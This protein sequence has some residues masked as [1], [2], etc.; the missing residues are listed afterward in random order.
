M[1]LGVIGCGNISP[2]YFRA[3]EYF[4][5]LEFIAC[6]DLDM[7]VARARAAEF[8]IPEVLPVSE[9]LEHPEIEVIVNLTVPQV[10]AAVS[11]AVLE[12]GKHVYS[13]KPLATSLEDA[14]GLLELADAK[15]LRVACAPL[16]LF[17]CGSANLP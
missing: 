3:K 17:R 16:D 7:D 13:E 1:K 8:N 9:L 12:A 6:S 2:L 11:K 10:H 14:Q 5:S 15:G 4:P